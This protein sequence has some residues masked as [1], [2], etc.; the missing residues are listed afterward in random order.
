MKW[1]GAVKDPKDVATKEYV[2]NADKDIIKSISA[3]GNNKVNY[4][5]IISFTDKEIMDLWNQYIK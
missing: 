3:L 1:L 2:D 4:E 5:D